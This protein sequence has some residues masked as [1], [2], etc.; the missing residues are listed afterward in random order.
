MNLRTSADSEPFRM[1][2]CRRFRRTHPPTGSARAL[3]RVARDVAMGIAASRASLDL[4][5]ECSMNW[6]RARWAFAAAMPVAVFLNC[7]D[8]R[9]VDTTQQAVAVTGTIVPSTPVGTLPGG[10]IT[11]GTDGSSNYTIPLE[12]PRGRAGMEP[13]LALRYSSHGGNGLLGVSWSLSGFSQITRCGSTYAHDGVRRPVK[14]DDQ[15]HFCLDGER[16]IDVGSGW[17]YRPETSTFARVMVDNRDAAGPTAWT[18][19][20]KDLQ[21]LH[22]GNTPDSRLESSIEAPPPSYTARL[23]WSLNRREDRDGNYIAYT[24][25]TV[26]LLAGLT[27]AP[28]RIEYT[29][30]F[31]LAPNRRI[32]FGYESRLD[33]ITAWQGGV[34][35]TISQRLTTITETAPT[36]PGGTLAS[37]VVVRTYKLAYGQ[38][39][40]SGRSILQSATLCDG[41]NVCLPATTFSYTQP[42]PSFASLPSE[43]V[44][45]GD[46]THVFDAATDW[47]LFADFNG[48]GAADLLYYSGSAPATERYN[49]RLA[50]R[51]GMAPG[52][53]PTM[54]AFSAGAP[55]LG[56][57][58]Y[59]H[60]RE[61]GTFANGHVVIRPQ[62]ADLYDQL[63]NLW[64]AGCGLRKF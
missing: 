57:R 38:S 19:Y 7:N 14:V 39:S 43:R 36:A 18:V 52:F 58:L 47:V 62:T 1:I 4:T 9:D 37:S 31:D 25:A 28:Y 6:L 56:Q 60:Y 26:N 13:T 41:A 32:E 10:R 17:E 49:I 59:V 22:Y 8:T 33:K 12:V 21:I 44:D 5:Q 3:Q 54:R 11:V 61:E 51:P 30:A 55:S 24:Y 53:G 29:G 48:D 64:H 40:S 27:H 23:G 63:G 34:G 50:N 16:L 45:G 46:A 2:V 35:N 42:P 15:D 20:T